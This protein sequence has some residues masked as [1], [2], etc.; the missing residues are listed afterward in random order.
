MKHRICSTRTTA[1]SHPHRRRA[2]TAPEDTSTY[3]SIFTWLRERLPGKRYVP[4]VCQRLA[5]LVSGLLVKPTCTLGAL[6]AGVEGL[7]VS[8]AG[9]ESIE[10]RLRRTLHDERLDPTTVLS[11]L[12]R[13]VLPGLLASL[14][15][16]AASHPSRRRPLVRII[17]DESS[18]PRRQ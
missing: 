9:A 16:Q 18:H 3:Q 8:E 6:A 13:A 14:R 4:P 15:E 7:A 1:S 12:F 5:I 2:V 11:E 10:R 17:V